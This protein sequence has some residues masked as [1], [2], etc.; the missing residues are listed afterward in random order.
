M[1]VA[2]DHHPELHR[3]I[4]RLRPEQAEAVPSVVLQLVVDNT[5]ADEAAAPAEQQRRRRLPFGGPIEA[6]PDLA[7]RSSDILRKELG[8]TGQ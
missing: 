2:P 5:P 4:D 6:E 1:S 7:T 8:D 3:L